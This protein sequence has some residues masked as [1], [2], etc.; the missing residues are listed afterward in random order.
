MTNDKQSLQPIAH[1]YKREL[2]NSRSHAAGADPSQPF[3]RTASIEN[4]VLFLPR[5]KR[6]KKPAWTKKL[7]YLLLCDKRQLGFDVLFVRAL[8]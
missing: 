8:I 5:P 2:V 4:G 6:C 3:K 1:T 7:M